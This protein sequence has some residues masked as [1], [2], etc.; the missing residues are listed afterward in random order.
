MWDWLEQR[1][2][3]KSGKGGA[4]FLM[5]LRGKG[6]HPASLEE[7]FAWLREAGFSAGC[8]HLSLNRA[9]LAAVK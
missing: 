6:D 5:G 4:Q 9:L 2:E 3:H 1:T 7:H 8:L